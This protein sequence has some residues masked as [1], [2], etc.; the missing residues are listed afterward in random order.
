MPEQPQQGLPELKSRTTPQ[1]GLDQRQQQP[2]G[3]KAHAAPALQ[4]QH[5]GLAGMVDPHSLPPFQVSCRVKRLPDV[6]C[7]CLSLHCTRKCLPGSLLLSCKRVLQA[8]A[9][10]TCAAV[11]GIEQHLGTQSVAC[12]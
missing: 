6:Q 7:L 2:V 5:Q 3:N 4:R 10:L 9:G 12:T 8:S 1:T 11:A